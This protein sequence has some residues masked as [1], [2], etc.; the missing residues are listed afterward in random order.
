MAG[1]SLSG[2]ASGMDWKSIVTQLMAVERTPQDKARSKVTSLSTR[3]TALDSIKASLEAFQT[4]AKGLSF[5]TG[6]SSPRSASLVGNPADASVTTADSA[7]V[8]TFQVIVGGSRTAQVGTAGTYSLLKG[9]NGSSVSS[10]LASNSTLYGRASSVA[11]PATLA[12]LKLSDYG[13]TEGTVTVGNTVVTIAAS[14]L[15]L[16]VSDFLS[17]FSTSTGAGVSQDGTTGAYTLSAPVDPA[18]PT[19]PQSIGNPGDTSNFLSVLGFSQ[20]A[21]SPNLTMVQSVP[22][23]ILGIIPLSSLNWP[24]GPSDSET[25]TI[26]GVALGPFDGTST[27]YT[28]NSLVSVI[29]SNTRV[30]VTASIDPQSQRLVLTSTASGRSGISV[31]GNLAAALG[32]SDSGTAW[33]ETST[34]P[35]NGSGYF[36]RGNALEFNLMYNGRLVKDASGNELLTSDSNTIDLSRFGFGSTKITLSPTSDLTNLTSPLTYTAVVGGAASQAKKKIEDFISSYNSLSQLVTEKTKIT[37]GA[38]GKVTTSILSDN[39]E[40]GG[41]ASKLRLLML[42]AISD[43]TN[44]KISESYDSLSKIGLGFSRAGVMSIT[45]SATLDKALLNAPAAVDA[46]LNSL[47]TSAVSTTQGVGI[48]V[49]GLVDSFTGTSGLFSTLAS[50]I[51]S[52]TERLQKQISDLDRTLSAKQKSL[53]NSFIAMEKAQSMMQSQASALTQAFSSSNSK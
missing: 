5:G 33:S 12:G 44:S 8:G 51:R 19:A 24:S 3:Q 2:L 34:A 42:G 27:S 31:S 43:A 23:G 22:S 4:A 36:H 14:D 29:N 16:S 11:S 53:E 49:S 15:A 21:A 32:L 30:G 40:M 20:G 48:R 17:N 39:K 46:L 13:V 18:N 10:G 35:A 26:N 37:V 52:Q 45:D 1:L 38:D 47:G 28:L 9:T 7:T 50:S 25:L 41:L 6:T